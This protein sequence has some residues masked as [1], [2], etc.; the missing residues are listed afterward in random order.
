MDKIYTQFYDK[1]NITEE[2]ILENFDLE[3]Y[4]DY[5][6]FIHAICGNDNY[7]LKN[8]YCHVNDMSEDSKVI[9]TPWDLD[10]TFGYAWNGEWPTFLYEEKSSITKVDGLLTNSEYINDALK[11]RYFDLRK[12]ILSIDNI[13]EIIDSL[14]ESITYVI[15]KDSQRWMKTD[16][17]LEINK[18]KEWY[19]RRVEF[20]DSYLGGENV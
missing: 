17:D 12:N 19:K 6:I 14:H 15:D 8:V 3:N 18:I 4:I 9:L 5:K 16:L 2:Y 13:F 7:G 10:M 1:Q 20:L 11:E